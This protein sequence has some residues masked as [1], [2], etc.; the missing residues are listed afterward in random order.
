MYG[1]FVKLYNEITLNF[2]ILYELNV[3]SFY[4]KRQ[5]TS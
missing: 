4:T 2:L 3:L 5:R 1:Y